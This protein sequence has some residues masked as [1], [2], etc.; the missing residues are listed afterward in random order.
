MDHQ[1]YVFKIVLSFSESIMFSIYIIYTIHAEFIKFFV[2]FTMKRE[3]PCIA[4]LSMREMFWV[5]RQQ[6]SPKSQRSLGCK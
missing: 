4:S 2:Y 1:C 5:V 6:Q 3:I